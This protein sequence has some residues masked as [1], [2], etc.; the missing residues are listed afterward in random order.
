MVIPVIHMMTRT[1]VVKI[2]EGAVKHS[3]TVI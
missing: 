3:N 1:S 2:R